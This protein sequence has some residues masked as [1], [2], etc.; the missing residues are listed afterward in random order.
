VSSLDE[1]KEVQSHIRAMYDDYE[2][3]EATS[4]WKILI[5]LLY[6]QDDTE[7]GGYPHSLI[8]ECL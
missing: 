5:N 2:G 3:D 4:V 7:T 6:L 8:I 1:V